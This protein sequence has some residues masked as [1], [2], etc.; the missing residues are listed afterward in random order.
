[1]ESTL[2]TIEETEEDVRAGNFSVA[3][4]KLDAIVKEANRQINNCV[5]Y[6]LIDEARLSWIDGRILYHNHDYDRAAKRYTQAEECLQRI[7]PKICFT[8]RQRNS[9]DKLRAIRHQTCLRD[10]LRLIVGQLPT[11]KAALAYVSCLEHVHAYGQPIKA[12]V[13]LLFGGP[14]WRSEYRYTIR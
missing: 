2:P 3:Q 6:D 10:I 7:N 14:L 5:A 9:F 1:M 12:V 8:L 11:P 4:A 13:V